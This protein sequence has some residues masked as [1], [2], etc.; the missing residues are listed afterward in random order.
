MTKE[1]EFR[2]CKEILKKLR[3][4]QKLALLEDLD[5]TPEKGKGKQMA[6]SIFV[7][8]LPSMVPT[9]SESPAITVSAKPA[10]KKRE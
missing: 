7:S 10:K 3:G 2:K 5:K 4:K 8:A 1:E 6:K 9:Q